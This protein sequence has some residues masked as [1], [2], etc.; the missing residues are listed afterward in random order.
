MKRMYFKRWIS[1]YRVGKKEA[2]VL[3]SEPQLLLLY[4][5]YTV[6]IYIVCIPSTAVRNRNV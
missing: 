6:Y 2:H 5:V 3:T 1:V 4:Y